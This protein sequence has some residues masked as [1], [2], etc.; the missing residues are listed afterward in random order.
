MITFGNFGFITAISQIFH[1]AYSRLYKSKVD[2][3]FFLAKAK[4]SVG[5]TTD[6]P[7]H[8]LEFPKK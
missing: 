2:F 5:L 8:V 6:L 3:F 4:L 7:T 1:P